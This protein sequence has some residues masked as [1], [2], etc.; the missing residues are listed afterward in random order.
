M[1]LMYIDACCD[2]SSDRLKTMSVEVVEQ[3][4]TLDSI[5]YTT[6]RNN[7]DDLIKV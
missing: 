4:Y 6:N 2:L 5:Q 3:T 1:S 7:K